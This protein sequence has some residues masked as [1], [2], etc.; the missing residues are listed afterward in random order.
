MSVFHIWS[1]VSFK[2]IYWLY[3]VCYVCL[4]EFHKEAKTYALSWYIYSPPANPLHI[5]N[6]FPA[7]PEA[8][9]LPH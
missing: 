8:I 3:K 9:F 6:G 5:V 2:G 1:N 4:K 7:C